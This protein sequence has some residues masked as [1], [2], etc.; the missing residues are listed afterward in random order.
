MSGQR[1]PMMAAF[2]GV[3]LFAAGLA[4][5]SRLQQG[6]TTQ[7]MG[8][9]LLLG[10][11]ATLGVHVLAYKRHQP[12][13]SR[14]GMVG[15][16]LGCLLG[17]S[18]VIADMVTKDKSPNSSSELGS[19]LL[20]NLQDPTNLLGT[21]LGG[22]S[23]FSY[24]CLLTGA[25]CVVAFRF[26]EYPRWL[27]VAPLLLVVGISGV[28][29]QALAKAA[30][31]SGGFSGLGLAGAVSISLMGMLIFAAAMAIHERW[32]GGSENMLIAASWVLLAGYQALSTTLQFSEKGGEAANLLLTV[33]FLILMLLIAHAW[34]SLGTMLPVLA[35]TLSLSGQ[36][37]NLIHSSFVLVVLAAVALVAGYAAQQQVLAR[38]TE[39]EDPDI[40]DMR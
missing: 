30:A 19:N 35:G 22:F 26:T 3:L 9:L 18:I 11:L 10:G 40:Y 7:G 27:L 23:G 16:V 8:G 34:T 12:V 14:L 13:I 15:T 38:N 36:L 33:V 25:I 31:S 39:D 20:S 2:C 1:L 29:A 21:M 28:V 24:A 6:M 5:L 17:S 4:L 37:G 32:E